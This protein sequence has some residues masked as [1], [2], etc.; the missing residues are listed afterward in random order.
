M[1]DG[2]EPLDS[3]RATAKQ[4]YGIELASRLPESG[5]YDLIS[6]IHSL[7]HVHDPVEELKA[8]FACWQRVG[9]CWSK[10]LIW[11][12]DLFRPSRREYL[13][14]LPGHLFHFTPATLRLVARRARLELE[15][16]VVRNPAL[17]E[18]AFALM[19]R[20]FGSSAVAPVPRA[21]AGT[22]E[23]VAR[24]RSGRLRARW[25]DTALP[26]LRERFPGWSF[27]VVARRAGP[28]S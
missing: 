1:A 23:S 3:G 20:L 22:S 26:W 9:A 17:L 24:S 8:A 10:Y 25:R 15:K 2:V 19:A 6:L 12:V 14:S 5:A 28:S 27:L 18:S 7:E 16:V 4:L 13:L 11:S 21:T